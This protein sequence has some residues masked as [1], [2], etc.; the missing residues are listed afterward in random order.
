MIDVHYLKKVRLVSVPRVQKLVA[1]LFLTPNYH[2]FSKVDIQID[3]LENIPRHQNVIFA[4][5]HTDRF[6]YWPF[7]YQLWRHRG[8]PYTTVWV[9]GAYYRNRL[10][11][12]CFDLV[13]AIPVPSMKYL[14][15]ECFRRRFGRRIGP[16]EYRYLKDLV[17]G[18]VEPLQQLARKSRELVILLQENF[19]PFVRGQYEQVMGMVAKLSVRALREQRLNLIIFPEGTRSLTLG[20]G[21]TGLAQLALYTE[22]PVVPVGCNNS[23]KIYPG[24]SPLA[25]SGRVIYRVGE[26]LDVSHALRAFRIRQPFELFSE[27][28]RKRYRER[29]EG[30]TLT[31][32]DRIN[33]LVDAS[34]R[35]EIPQA[36]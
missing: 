21:R 23:E 17:D 3:G 6:N 2:W 26:P 24:D 18:R 15:E 12:R 35:T 10:L 19:V 11:A 32:M 29:F 25:R 20:S 33:Q 7:Q 4:M 5:N 30:A 9:K 22:A 36:V 34:Y 31:I 13:N 8:F 1:L 28:S 27:T 14:I 16:D